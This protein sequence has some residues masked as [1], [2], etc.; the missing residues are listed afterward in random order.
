MRQAAT[1]EDRQHFCTYEQAYAA[2][3]EDLPFKSNGHRHVALNVTTG[4]R[5]PCA[6]AFI[7]SGYVAGS[8]ALFPDWV[9]VLEMGEE[10]V[11]AFAAHGNFLQR[12]QNPDWQEKEADSKASEAKKRLRI[13]KAQEAYDEVMLDDELDE[14]F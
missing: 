6:D 13:I 14:Y 8:S 10:R 9:F 4:H 5:I 7:A 3:P 2:I 11:K 12:I 1:V